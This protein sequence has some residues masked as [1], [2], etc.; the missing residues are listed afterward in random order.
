[1]ALL[2]K[3]CVYGLRA[4]LYVVARQEGRDYVPIGE[5]AEALGA[6]FHFL[7]K[8]LQDLTEQGLML[9]S[10][11]PAGGVM[12]TRS[13]REITVLELIE[14]LDGPE[15][16]SECVLGLGGCGERKPCPLHASWAAQRKAL[17]TLFAHATLGELGHKTLEAGLRLAD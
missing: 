12:L 11:G 16:F 7:T 17:R 13:A 2:S 6:S 10:R 4:V 14:S 8:I 1:M 3:R 9:S 15:L 5:I